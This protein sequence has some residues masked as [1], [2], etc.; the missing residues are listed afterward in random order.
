MMISIRIY[1]SGMSENFRLVHH[2]DFHLRLKISL[3]CRI[4]KAAGIELQRQ[5][6]R[7][8]EMQISLYF[9]EI[10]RKKV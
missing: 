10:S 6:R 5:A 7:C 9:L 3:M 1:Q 2:D 8:F 4:R